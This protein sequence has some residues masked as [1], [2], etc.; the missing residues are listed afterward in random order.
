VSGHSVIYYIHFINNLLEGWGERERDRERESPTH[1]ATVKFRATCAKLNLIDTLFVI[2][3]LSFTIPLN[4]VTQGF[5]S[6]M[7]YIGDD[8]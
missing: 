8:M 7:Y 1:G 2:S 4:Y 3:L 5:P 6:E